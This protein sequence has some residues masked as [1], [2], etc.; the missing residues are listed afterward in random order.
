MS[1]E[2]QAHEP[3][4]THDLDAFLLNDGIFVTLRPKIDVWSLLP[5][6]D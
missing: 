3:F 2:M 5:N 6:R 4:Q 1:N